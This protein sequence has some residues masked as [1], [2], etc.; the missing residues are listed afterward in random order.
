MK[1][2]ELKKIYEELYQPLFLYALSLTHNRE[3][4]E[5]LVADVF[6]KAAFSYREGHFRSWAYR[7]MKNQF[8]N[9]VRKRKRILDKEEIDLENIAV[10]LEE[11][12]PKEE[13]RK[14][15]LYRK[16]DELDP[17]R[18][19]IMILS[20]T[21]GLPDKDIASICGISAENL[22]VIRHR[23]KEELKKQAEKEGI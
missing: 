20:W 6:V 12:I 19:Q 14:R 18:K 23:I 7:V 2:E 11:M 10:P 13:E 15:W 9:D 3:D 22:R 17:K 16:I 8:L 21:S 4:A 1:N 5:D